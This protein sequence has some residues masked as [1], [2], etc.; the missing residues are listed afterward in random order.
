MMPPAS[1]LLTFHVVPHLHASM[2]TAFS[3]ERLLPGGL[4]SEGDRNDA[5]AA[6]AACLQHG[7]HGSPL[8]VRK[9]RPKKLHLVQQQ[10]QIAFDDLLYCMYALR[11]KPP[12]DIARET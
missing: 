2:Y 8:Q 11:L 7:G 6:A 9:K 3:H 4:A 1:F 12:E 5:S 10:H